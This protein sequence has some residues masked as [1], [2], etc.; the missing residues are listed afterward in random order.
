[1]TEHDSGRKPKRPRNLHLIA[2]RRAR[3]LTQQQLLTRLER[4][5]WHEM[6]PPMLKWSAALRTYQDW[7]GG[8]NPRDESK[9]VLTSY[10]GMSAAAL[11][12]AAVPMPDVP[13]TPRVPSLTVTTGDALPVVPEQEDDVN[14]RRFITT[15]PALVP[16][17]AATPAL[18]GTAPVMGMEHVEQIRADTAA[19]KQLDASSGGDAVLP[20]ADQ[21]V[22]RAVGLLSYVRSGRVGQALYSA[23]GELT[24][25]AAWFAHDADNHVQ[26]QSYLGQSLMWARAAEDVPAEGYVYSEA[27]ALAMRVG[28]GGQALRFAQLGS[29][30]NV[31]PALFAA[32]EARAYGRLGERADANAAIERAWKHLGQTRSLPAWAAY[33][34][35]VAIWELAGNAW[36]ELGDHKRAVHSLEKSISAAGDTP[37]VRA[38]ANRQALL[39]DARLQ[40]D[41]VEGACVAAEAAWRCHVASTRV[42]N[43]LA[44]F[45]KKLS[46]YDARA[47]REFRER[48]R[49]Q[50]QASAAT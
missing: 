14:R 1:M 19:L 10:F 3:T 9:L 37:R 13:C 25:A 45:A 12:F 8:G 40:A 26:A 31:A 7:E 11:G 33:G 6:D 2:A 16:V 4:H 22:S 39:A 41:D 28:H 50:P 38:N 44:E 18:I 20:V 30:L 5:A 46:A 47:A 15:V 42:H 27:H 35:E 43:R 17:V 36:A 49:S 21:C 32:F 23:V 48:W 24:A 34:D 29:R